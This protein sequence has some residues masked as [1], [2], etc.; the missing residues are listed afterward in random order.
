MNAQ[1]ADQI[2]ACVKQAICNV[3]SMEPEEVGDNAHFTDDLELDSLTRVEV[4]VEIERALGIEFPGDGMPEDMHTVD[5]AV[6]MIAE[7]RT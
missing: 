1:D 5:D 7:L 6:R 3:N 2:R 4:M